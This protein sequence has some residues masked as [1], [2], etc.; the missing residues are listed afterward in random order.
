M[1]LLSGISWIK[2]FSVLERPG[3]LYQAMCGNCMQLLILF[4]SSSGFG[5]CTTTGV[6][7]RRWVDRL[8]GSKCCPQMLLLWLVSVPSW[9]FSDT[10]QQ[11]CI[12]CSCQSINCFS[13]LSVCNEWILCCTSKIAHL[14]ICTV[15]ICR[16]TLAL[17][18]AFVFQ[19]SANSD[20]VTWL[21]CGVADWSTPNVTQRNTAN[22]A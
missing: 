5:V 16:R 4:V 1:I 8:A 20:M 19:S 12:I 17:P 11:C 9:T 18:L 21:C 22:A 14:L 10:T 7:Y 13:A 15:L 6:F 3:K 2:W